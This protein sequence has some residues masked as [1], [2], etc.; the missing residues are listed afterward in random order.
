MLL[1]ALS[2]SGAAA[3][4]DTLPVNPV[5]DRHVRTWNITGDDWVAGVTAVPTSHPTRLLVHSPVPLDSGGMA[6]TYLSHWSPVAHAPLATGV[7]A[8]S[9]DASRFI[10]GE[11]AY[12]VDG[13]VAILDATTGE[14]VFAAPS[15]HFSTTGSAIWPWLSANGDAAAFTLWFGSAPR[16]PTGLVAP[17]DGV[18]IWEEASNG[19]RTIAEPGAAVHGASDDLQVLVVRNPDGR[20]VA[21]DCAGS[22][23]HELCARRTIGEETCRFRGLSPDGRYVALLDEGVVPHRRGLVD[24]GTGEETPLPPRG[25]GS[26]WVA[27]DQQSTRMLYSRAGALQTEVVVR[28]MADGHETVL[29]AGRVADLGRPLGF[30][31]GQY[32]V[33]GAMG[34]T[35]IDTNVISADGFDQFLLP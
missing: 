3:L 4:F 15:M 11:R 35:F 16:A 20:I 9:R 23:L 6:T 22:E 18:V 21:Y 2:L 29:D 31:A 28:F 33:L 26:S 5:G 7:V 17:V 1:L 12:G 30:V 27:F 19:V 13:S 10:T 8:L 32:A 14:A 34:T 24:L 25:N